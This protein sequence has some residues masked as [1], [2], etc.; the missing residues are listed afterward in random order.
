M[1]CWNP[2]LSLRG[3]RELR[4]GSNPLEK[5]TIRKNGETPANMGMNSERDGWLQQGNASREWWVSGGCG[6]K[7]NENLSE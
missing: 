6:G 3:S 2:R 1:R 7:V 5:E 4:G